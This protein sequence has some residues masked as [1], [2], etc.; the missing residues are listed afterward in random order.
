VRGGGAD[1]DS[2]SLISVPLAG[3]LPGEGERTHFTSD[4]ATEMRVSPDGRQVAFAERYNVYVAPFV[5]TG[6]PV[7]IGPKG[8]NLPIVKLSREAGNFLHWSGDSRALHWTL[9]P[10]LATLPVAEAMAGSAFG[11]AAADA[12]AVVPS[13]AQIRLDAAT[14]PPRRADGAASVIAITNVKILTMENVGGPDGASDGKTRGGEVIER[15]VIVVT[16]NRITAVGSA[17]QVAIPTGATLIDGQGGVVTPGFVDAHAHGAQ[18]ENGF[19]PQ[20]NWSAQAN[21]AFGVTTIHD[22]SNDTEAVFAASELA[23][24]GLILTPRIFSTGTI[25]YGAQGAYKAEI[26]SLDDALFHLKRLK[27]VGA[28]SVKSYNQPRRDQRQMVLEAAR[29]T[30]MMVV[31]EGGALYQHN[32]TMVVD[33]HTTVEHTLPIACIYDDVK[34]MWGASRVGYTPTLVVAYGG[35]GGENYWY[36][37]T[38]VWADKHLMTFVPRYVVDPRSR[39]RTDAPD[40]EWNHFQE[41]RIA[42]QVLDAKQAGVIAATGQLAGIGPHWELWM[43][44][45]GG[46][47]PLEALRAATIDGATQLGLDGDL[48]SLRPGKLADLLLFREDPSLEIRDSESIAMVMLNG[49]LY[50]AATLAQVAPLAAPGPHY[51][52]EELQKGSGT[53][54]A[55]EAIMRKAADSGAICAGCCGRH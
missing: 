23:K 13:T 45:Q 2:V 12:P 29:R 49:R 21:L 35:L 6:K 53:P 33:G 14:D 20:N 18:G 26:E 46:M 39:R 51:F 16:G 40:E 3:S 1:T 34:Q 55:V 31:P 43:L 52:F 47:T 41:G 22:P 42:K 9:G 48:G 27:A 11:G 38:D 30:G 37:K 15:G 10:E 5:D 32:M 28:F 24:A 54:L 4:W 7:A 25:L 36:A 19:T 8:T 44:A 50:D 17:D